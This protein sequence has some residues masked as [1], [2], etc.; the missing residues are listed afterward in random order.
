MCSAIFLRITDI[1]STRSSTEAE[2]GGGVYAVCGAVVGAEIAGATGASLLRSSL[3]RSEPH[4]SI[5]DMMSFFVTRPLRPDAG[6]P[7]I[8]MP[9]YFAL[10]RT[11]GLV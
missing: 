1:F 7:D 4:V 10:S 9:C 8:P 11:R 5:T 2:I 6:M 3:G